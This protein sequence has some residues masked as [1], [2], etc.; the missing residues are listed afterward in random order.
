LQRHQQI[1]HKLPV[2]VKKARDGGGHGGGRW[3][4]VLILSQILP[5]FGVV[6]LC[7]KFMQCGVGTI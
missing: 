1:A 3:G 5:L 2:L 4:E 7:V 6:L